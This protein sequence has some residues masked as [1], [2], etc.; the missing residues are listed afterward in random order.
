MK[1][2]G[3]VALVTGAS[4]G[5][6]R[7]I[8][9]EL[10]THGVRCI[11]VSRQAE[12]KLHNS[13]LVVSKNCDVGDP[14]SVAALLQW[15]EAEYGQ[16]DILVNN[17]GL[18]QKLGSVEDLDDGT[19][20]QLIHTNLLGSIYVT[21]CSLP[22]LKKAPEAELVNVISKSGVV[23]QAGQSVYTATKYGLRG[24][25]DVLREDL[26]ES[27]VH[28]MAVYQAGTNTQMFGKVGDTPPLEK[29]TEPADL[30]RYI[31]SAL[32]APAKF[33]AKEL[34]IDYK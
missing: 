27:S 2:S 9:D 4:E 31:V 18:W 16:L 1:L 10:V 29:F 28:I 23:A 11:A 30:A 25:T 14:A 17:A 24:F 33:W 19:I 6:G 5:I 32:A 3:K 34:H 22:L 13:E 15:V 8:V 20:A 12:T 21:K 26:K 7:A